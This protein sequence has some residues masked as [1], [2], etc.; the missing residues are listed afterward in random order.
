MQDERKHETFLLTNS[1]HFDLDIQWVSLL[2][3]LLFFLF[4]SSSS[5]LSLPLFLYCLPQHS[6]AFRRVPTRPRF[7]CQTGCQI[8]HFFCTWALTTSNTCHLTSLSYIS[9]IWR[10]L[11]FM[12]YRHAVHIPIQT[13]HVRN[14]CGEKWRWVVSNSTK[15]NLDPNNFQSPEF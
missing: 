6:T 8:T 15:E 14:I 5:S 11:I 10:L 3:P 2:G 1:I 7:F 13:I 9:E 4:F 12:P